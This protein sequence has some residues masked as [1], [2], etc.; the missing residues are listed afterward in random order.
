MQTTMKSIRHLIESRTMDQPSMGIT[1]YLESIKSRFGNKLIGIFMY[2][3]RLSDL[4]A[5]R[6]SFP[7]FFVIT[8][9]YRGVFDD[10]SHFI[11][12]FPLPPHIY[13]LILDPDHHCKY[14]LVS[15]SRFQQETSAW[16]SDI[17]ILGR[18]GK[19]VSLVYSRDPESQ[20]ALL[21]CCYNAMENVALWTLRGM[22]T[23]F[24]ETEFTLACLNIS[25]A[26]E[27]RVETHTKVPKLYQSEK[28]FYQQV[29]PGFLNA[30]LQ[31]GACEKTSSGKYLILGSGFSTLC[32]NKAYHLF[33]KNS[34]MRGLLR[35]PKFLLTVDQWVD[36]ILAKIERTKGIKLNPSETAKKYPLLLG[37][38]Y[39]FKLLKA[40][41][42]GSFKTTPDKST[43]K[44]TPKRM[45]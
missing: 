36:I 21:N 34:R 10:W 5:T 15:L 6:T 35:W 38:P 14:N 32:K 44:N 24:D 4:T 43:I 25:Y 12:A 27:H 8:D 18:F 17:Y 23:E 13:H 26:G 3:S 9:G 28:G 2:G 30:L 37:W 7:D 1:P 22:N 20:H 42:I 45:P 11:S 39:L 33:L 41:A 16:A 40:G 31:Q 29:Y 19:R